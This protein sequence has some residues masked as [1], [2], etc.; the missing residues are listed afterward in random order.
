MI[1]EESMYSVLLC[2]LGSM[3]WNNLPARDTLTKMELGSGM[4]MAN[5][6]TKSKTKSTKQWPELREMAIEDYKI[7]PG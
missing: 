7:D 5:P 2:T 6:Q 3:K 1:I 4:Q